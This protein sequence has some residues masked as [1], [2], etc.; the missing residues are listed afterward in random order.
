MVRRLAITLL[1]LA[2]APGYAATDPEPG[3]DPTTLLTEVL[4]D[5][6]ANRLFEITLGSGQFARGYLTAV[7]GDSLYLREQEDGGTTFAYALNEIIL[8]RQWHTNA[9]GGA[10][11]GA[12]T[13]AVILG[14]FGTLVGLYAASLDTGDNDVGPVVGLTMV[15]AG[16]GALA[17]GLLGGG[18]GALISSWHEIWPEDIGPPLPEPPRRSRNTRLGLFAGLGNARTLELDY[19]R[20]TGRVTLH[21]ALGKAASLG[22]EI[23]YHDFGGPVITY[24][25]N[26]SSVQQTAGIVAFSLGAMVRNRSLGLGP[27]L[28]MG[29]GWYLS[30]AS[31]LGAHVGGGL[32]WQVRRSLDFSLDIRY[33]FSF[34]SVADDEIDEFWTLG[35]EL[36]L[37]I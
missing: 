26:G 32:R 27:Y 37:G 10:G 20:F 34:T 25:D 28:A 17:G 18:M 6:P 22:P 13:G 16:M 24:Q 29:T 5:Q 35:L 33:H 23:A 31:F 36:G 14:G 30:D 4:R 9:S 11:W 15:G 12:T 7:R 3:P 2:T 1:F 19:S 21:K 8:V